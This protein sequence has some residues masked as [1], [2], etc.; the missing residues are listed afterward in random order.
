MKV[1]LID[2]P[3]K[4]VRE[5]VHNG[6]YREIQTLIHAD[7]FAVVYLDDTDAVFVDDEGLINDNPHGW[8]MLKGYA[9]PLRG[10]GLVCGHDEEGDTT[11]PKISKQALEELLSF[12]DDIELGPPESYAKVEITSFDSAEDML[13][14][15]GLV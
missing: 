5:V 8:F 14:H 3:N 12:P 9:Q 13:K 11:S 6:D 10:Y 2:T 1:L 15:M 4:C 7:L